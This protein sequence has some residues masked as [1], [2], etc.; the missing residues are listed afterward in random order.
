MSVRNLPA[1]SLTLGHRLWNVR[2]RR[3]EMTPAMAVNVTTKLWEIVV[4]VDAVDAW[5]ASERR[6]D[7]QPFVEAG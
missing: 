4:I 2:I 5:E 1:G 6:S 3:S 7:E